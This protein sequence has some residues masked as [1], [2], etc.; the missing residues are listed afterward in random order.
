MKNVFQLKVRVLVGLL[1][2]SGLV[3]CPTI[4]FAAAE[5]RVDSLATDNSPFVQYMQDPPWIRQMQFRQVFSD[6]KAAPGQT[7]EV[8][9]PLLA[10]YKGAIQP[11]GLYFV[12]RL[13]PPPPG[14]MTIPN[15]PDPPARGKVMPYDP[16]RRGAGGISKDHYWAVFWEGSSPAAGRELTLDPQSPNKGGSAENQLRVLIQL[17]DEDME[18]VRFFGFPA[19]LAHS[20]TVTESNTFSA[21]TSKKVHISGQFLSATNGRP[22]SLQYTLDNEAKNSFH[23]LTYHY[24]EKNDT[25]LP[26]YFEE[27]RIASGRAFGY[28]EGCWIDQLDAGMDEKVTAGYEP[29]LF[30]EMKGINHTVLWSNGVDYT[31]ASD[32]GMIANNHVQPSVF[33]GKTVRRPALARSVMI[34]IIFLSIMAAWAV[35]RRPENTQTTTKETYEKE[36]VGG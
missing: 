29:S 26:D 21:L 1:W 5:A 30:F 31:V 32:G 11:S 6:K 23:H 19:L 2:T 33:A 17:Y 3:L 14:G 12:R 24:R 34:S 22:E 16:E 15:D 9:A 35:L 28:P 10:T 18:R 36:V 4:S 8:T 7:P 25:M 13:P 27:T 20:F